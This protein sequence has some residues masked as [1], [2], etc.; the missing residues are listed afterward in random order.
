M[1]ARVEIEDILRALLDDLGASRVTLRQR[2]PSDVDAGLP[3]THEVLA[4]EA[5]SIRDV[6]TPDMAGQPVVLRVG[7]GEQVVQDDCAT[8]YPDHGPFNEMLGLYGGMRAQIVTPLVVG[9]ETRAV[10]SVHE[11]KATRA[12]TEADASRCRAAVEQLRTPLG[13]A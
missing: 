2:T 10:V 8:A 7:R 11:L 13:L 6:R 5:R 3:L 1:M 4:P 9:G 12:W